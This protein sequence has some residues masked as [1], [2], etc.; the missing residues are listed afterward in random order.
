MNSSNSRCYQE[1]IIR[2]TYNTILYILLIAYR[3]MKLLQTYELYK[4]TT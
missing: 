1:P 3:Y 4:K 2:S